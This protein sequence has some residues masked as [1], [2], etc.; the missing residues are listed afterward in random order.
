MPR[1]AW[2][3]IVPLLLLTGCYS[4]AEDITPPP[5]YQYEPQSATETLSFPMIAPDPESGKVIFEAKCLACHGA[6]GLGDGPQ[7]N[8]LPNPVAPIGDPA[9][10]RT[11]QP[12]AWYR[13][14]S[15]GNIDRFMPPFVSLSERERWDVLAYVYTLSTDQTELGTGENIYAANCAACH[16]DDASGTEIAPELTNQARM[17]VLTG[18]ALYSS[19]DHPSETGAA[20]FAVL[21]A[22]E[23][24]W[25]LVNYM[26][27]LTFIRT[28]QP[29]AAVLEVDEDPDAA[30][31]EQALETNGD[32]ES[33]ESAPAAPDPAGGIIR[34][35]I[36]NASGG[37]VP[38]DLEVILHGY[39][40]FEEVLT[41]TG[42][43]GED[44]AFVFESIDM[45]EGRAFLVTVDFQRGTFTS[46]IAVAGSENELQLPVNIYETTT[47]LSVI[48][49]AQ[50]HLLFEFLEGGTLRVA[51]LFTINNPTAKLVIAQD[52]EQIILDFEL[53]PNATN[54][55]FQDGEL[56]RRYIQTTTGFADTRAIQPGM[57]H[58]ILFSYDL[59]FVDGL[60]L[61]QVL[62][63]PVD[64]LIM[65][66][67]DNG[68][69]VDDPLYMDTGLQDIQGQ[70]YQ[71]YA[72]F[73][74][75]AGRLPLVLAGE[76]D[77]ATSPVIVAG[78]SVQLGV[79]VAVFSV[80]LIGAGLW[81]YRSKRPLS[82][83]PEG[84]EPNDFDHLDAS[85][86][87]DAII[88]LDD[89]Y[90]AGILQH[91]AYLNRRAALKTRLAELLDVQGS[92]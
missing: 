66:I 64:T 69:L 21:L 10:A 52:S 7:A 77:L 82:P 44:G 9:L 60:D 62:N 50:L 39:D 49:I 72:T 26:R 2:L 15:E 88:A 85:A 27:D 89:R 38:P 70:S 73:D 12:A 74:L 55:Q 20:D 86:L 43:V 79:G 61:S 45:P 6:R 13:I 19:L 68:V 18:E 56:G 48:E 81:V 34:G 67:P 16:G 36:A 76:A 4:L 22:A 84:P 40:D 25:A 1:Y 65:L 75:P 92:V 14:V 42:R 53:P 37:A 17:A 24:R 83:P 3:L 23:E 11:A 35:E 32:S 87:M 47:D 8:E 71:T 28:E 54:L 5:D 46:D 41:L 51:Q 33:A 80:A 31:I 63:Y 59:P 91:N 29:V 57:V 90:K 78:S 58:Q 30:S